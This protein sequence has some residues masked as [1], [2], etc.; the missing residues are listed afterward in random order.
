MGLKAM[1]TVDLNDVTREQ[2][3]K[4][5]LELEKKQWKKIKSLTTI[6]QVGFQDGATEASIIQAT[7]NDV[8]S[9]ASAAGIRS[10]DSGVMV[11]QNFPT[12]WSKRP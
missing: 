11:G 7:K 10:Y 3:E 5:Y 9:A 6:W 2:R 12:T 4:F 1:L 8:T